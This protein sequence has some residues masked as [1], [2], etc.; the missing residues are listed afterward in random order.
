LYVFLI[1]LLKNATG[2]NAMKNTTLSTII[3]ATVTLSAGLAHA[4]D[5]EPKINRIQLNE[6][7]REAVQTSANEEAR[8][9][10]TERH[11]DRIS[12]DKQADTT[13]QKIEQHRYRY[14]ER[15]EVNKTSRYGQGY[16]SRTRSMGASSHGGS[17][18]GRH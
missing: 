1:H 9:R 2:D 13:E 4:Q 12:Q 3:L 6:Q 5:A 7:V 17:G 10:K 14:Q 16:E 8:I 15:N 11:Q 18:S